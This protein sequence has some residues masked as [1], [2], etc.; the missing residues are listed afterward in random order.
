MNS[1]LD[2]RLKSQDFLLLTKLLSLKEYE[3]EKT[4]LPGL[5]FGTYTAA[6]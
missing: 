2:Q 1:F 3:K 5:F 4:S 6:A